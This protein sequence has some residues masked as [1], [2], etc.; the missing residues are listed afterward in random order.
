M[1][2][3]LE[4]YLARHGE[5][6]NNPLPEARHTPDP[7]LTPLGERQAL[8]LAERLV[9]LRPAL[10]LSSPLVRAMATAAPLV[11][12]SGAA[13]QV[14]EE[15]AEAHRAHPQDGGEV[16]GLGT[17]F[18]RAAFTD[19]AHWPGFPGAETAADALA[20]GRR[21]AARLG[22]LSGGP[23]AIIG[24]QNL[25]SYL[26][27]AWLGLEAHDR[28]R[29]RQDNAAVHHLRLSADGVEL[30]RLNDGAHLHRLA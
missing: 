16:A 3:T 17:R 19:T 20:R 25:N 14:W 21:L 15:L 29:F 23:V 11:A 13:W 9:A 8:V 30:V 6:T 18:P 12:E 22:N 5:S 10:V 1:P 27:R 4:I 26:L 28:V 24:H 2:A 7:E